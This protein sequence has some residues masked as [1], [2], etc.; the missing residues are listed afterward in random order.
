MEI[1]ESVIV[2]PATLPVVRERL[3]DALAA[4]AFTFRKEGFQSTWKRVRPP[5]KPED[6]IP[7]EIDSVFG[8]RDRELL[9]LPRKR[10]LEFVPPEED[11]RRLFEECDVALYNARILNEALA[12]STPDFFRSNPVIKV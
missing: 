7:L 6:G 9:Q 10:D 8:D 11:T 5:N 2:S 4:A 1:V 3:I 12:Y